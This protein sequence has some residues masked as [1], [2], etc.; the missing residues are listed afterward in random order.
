VAGQDGA[1]GAQGDA[2]ADGAQ[3]PQ[4]QNAALAGG[5]FYSTYTNLSYY[6]GTATWAPG[7][8]IQLMNS[9]NIY[10]QDGYTPPSSSTTSGNTNASNPSGNTGVT[11]TQGTY[12]LSY[13]L[14]G[15]LWTCTTGT[16]LSGCSNQGNVYSNTWVL[17]T[18]LTSA[19]SGEIPGSR[20]GTQLPTTS[21]NSNLGTQWLSIANSITITVG[22]GGDTITLNA[23]QNG[24][25]GALGGNQPSGS[26]VMAS[27]NVER[28][29]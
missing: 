11:L 24:Y 3:G 8:A 23:G 9:S 6:G 25:R 29:Q 19:A 15:D 5:Y 1:Q 12:E 28:V 26:T 27:I 17:S 4:G 21:T 16:N 7:M 10:A 13:M 22:A 18:Y 2:G 20:I 14:A